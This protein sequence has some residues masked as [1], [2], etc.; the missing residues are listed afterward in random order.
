MGTGIRT[1]LPM[2]AADELDADWKL[3][4]IQQAVG[5]AKY[6]SQDT[7]GSRSIRDFYS[8]IREAGARARLML[9]RAAAALWAVPAEECRARN[10]RMVHLASNRSLSFGELTGHASRQPVPTREELRFKTPDEFRFIGKGVPIVDITDICTGKAGYGIDA[11]VPGMVFA[12]I[13]RPPVLG[14]RLKSYEDKETLNVKGAKETFVIDEAQPPYA[15]QALGGVAVVADSTWAAM[16]GRKKLKVDWEPGDNA[17]YESESYRKMLLETARKLQK[18]IR[19]IGDVDAEFS[20]TEKIYEAE[21]YVP[22]LAHASM[23]PPTAVAEYKNGEITV[24]AATQNPQAVQDAVAAA[25]KISKKSVICH[26]TL[27]GGGFGRKSKPD[28][29]VEAA[30]IKAS[31]GPF[32]AQRRSCRKEKRNER[33]AGKQREL[34]KQRRLS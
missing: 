5:D 30:H 15:F 13:E 26:V 25:V 8:A 24:W 19:D 1:A 14:G 3:V 2:V 32:T 31:A 23:E 12:S 16:E 10:H 17:A 4:R 29:V 9:E 28:Y 27:L 11:R 20:R 22:L 33:Q 34:R 18:V 6:G 21:Y 7:D